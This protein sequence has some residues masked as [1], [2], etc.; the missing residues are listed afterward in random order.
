VLEIAVFLDIITPF[1]GLFFKSRK[2]SSGGGLF[3]LIII[4]GILYY[5]GALPVVWSHVK[6]AGNSCYSVMNSAGIGGQSICSGLNNFMGMI[7]N[8]IGGMGSSVGGLFSGAG[9]EFD[10][11]WANS[12]I[13]RQLEQLT[14]AVDDAQLSASGLMSNQAALTALMQSGP[15]GLKIPSTDIGQL[16]GAMDSFAIGK[17]LMGTQPQLGMQWLQHGAS[18]GEYGLMPQISLGNAYMQ[19]GDTRAA[20]AYF[21]QAQQSLTQLRGSNSAASQQLLGSLP[22]SPDALQKQ[23]TAAIRQMQHIK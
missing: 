9:Q 19:G 10:E 5:T 13:R 14:S 18:A 23:I 17:Q 8:S 4:G 15:G 11:S 7:D 22:V 21:T 16:K 3:G 20:M 2:R 6:N 12:S 1:M